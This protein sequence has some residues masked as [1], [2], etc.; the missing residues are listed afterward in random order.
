MPRVLGY[1]RA[2]AGQN[3]ETSL[4]DVGLELEVSGN[5]IQGTGRGA[6]VNAERV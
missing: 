5:G 1:A 2:W 3:L 4:Q 6:K